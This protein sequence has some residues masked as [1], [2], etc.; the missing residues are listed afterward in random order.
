MDDLQNQSLQQPPI[1]ADNPT[2]TEVQPTQNPID[3]I[4]RNKL[5]AYVV[6]LMQKDIQDR[7]SFGWTRLREYDQLSYDGMR[8]RTDDP[9][10]N[11]S[12]YSVCLTPTMLDTGHSNTIGSM[13]SND[14]SVVQVKGIGPEDVRT[15]K[16]L[17][18]LLNW[19]IL[20]QI[21]NAYA[22]CDSAVFRAFKFGNAVV[23]CSQKGKKGIQWTN[24]PIENIIVPLNAIG[25]M[26]DETDHI[27]QIIPLT[28]ND[29]EERKTWKDQKTGNPIY[30]NL[31]KLKPGTS[32]MYSTASDVIINAADRSSGTS[33]SQKFARDMSYMVEF[34]CTYWE[35]LQG[36]KEATCLELIVWIAPQ[37][38]DIFRLEINELYD[39]SRDRFVRPFSTKWKPYPRED[40]FYGDSLPFLIR[41]T[42]EELDYIHNQT[43]NAVEKMIKSPTFYDPASGI[44]P[45]KTQQTPN[46]WY[47]VPKPREN[48]FIPTYDFS[49]ILNQERTYQLFWEY[50]QRR[51]GFTELFQG[52]APNNRQT[53]GEAKLRTAKTEI[54]FSTVYKRFE[55]GFSELLE[56]TYFYDKKFL[57][58]DTEIKVLGTNDYSTTNE[59]FPD[60]LNGN[61]NFYFSS[62]PLSEREQLREDA[63][64][65]YDKAMLNPAVNMNPAN[66]YNVLKFY[67]DAYNI[68]NFEV[69]V[70][71]PP[72]AKAMTA[73]EA[74]QR[75]SSGQYDILPE[76][77]IDAQEYIFELQKFMRTEKFSGAD[78]RI[79]QG[80]QVLLRRAQ[81]VLYG[82]NLALMDSMKLKSQMAADQ[83]GT[84]IPQG[85][86]PQPGL[87]NVQQQPQPAGV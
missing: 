14:D 69:M 8:G 11:A 48:I 65:F 50:A 61:Y 67:A 12:N 15:E 87:G 29:I 13:F 30:E 85:N 41:Q 84:G 63:T 5:S 37:G 77:N 68:P 74:I 83:Q 33:L 19:Q 43:R 53:L 39:E 59:L 3:R 60:G 22:V 34:Y 35:T 36:D 9:W 28:K 58:K 25:A 51:T 55:L 52:R 47:P 44:D 86:S 6:G 49:P 54:R 26:S 62:S 4:D 76:P 45:E 2:A 20:N 18:I 56:L 10:F 42:Q 31:D 23:K 81:Q 80:I 82:Q 57:P 46:G 72:E 70:R 38:G 32:V 1:A 73:T 64:M 24:V 17:G 79:Q 66:V 71:M 16:N 21:P 40:R 78:Q 7:D 27:G 75:I